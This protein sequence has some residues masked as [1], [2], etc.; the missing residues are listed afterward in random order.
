MF[1]TRLY[2][3]PQRAASRKAAGNVNRLH[4]QVLNA[5][6]PD[7]PAKHPLWRLDREK[8][9]HTLYVVSSTTP[10]M[11]AFHEEYGWENHPSVTADYSPRLD[12]LTEGQQWA[13]RLTANP[14]HT[15]EYP[16]E[17][18]VVKTINGAD[19]SFVK[20]RR[21]PH[22]T[23]SHQL[24]WLNNQKAKHNGFKVLGEPTTTPLTVN[25]FSKTNGSSHAVTI[26]STTFDG[27]LEV[28]DSV[29]L[30][31]A[32][33]GGIGRARAYGCGLMTIAPVG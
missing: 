31:E 32:L 5:F 13:F 7:T 17:P 28:T 24:A 11:R 9:R 30:R 4:A 15:V 10:D 23:R 16:N 6:G 1:L 2:L 22:E 25:R 20:T 27:F 26:A 8:T 12:S 14:V 21:I 33:T 18:P 3:N 19:K 29:A